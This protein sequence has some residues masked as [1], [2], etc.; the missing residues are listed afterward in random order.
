MSELSIRFELTN[1]QRKYFALEPVAPHWTRIELKPSTY[2]LYTTIAYLD[3]NVVRKCILISFDRYT[4]T[5]YN[6]PLSDDLQ[7]LL[8]KTA[9]GKPVRLTSANLLKRKS[10]GMCLHYEKSFVS[11]YSSDNERIYYASHYEQGPDNFENWVRQWCQDSTLD[12]IQNIHQFAQE[13]KNH[14]KYHEGD[15]FRFK[16]TRR[17]Y[18]YGRILLDYN[19]LRKDKVPFWDIWMSTPVVCSVYHIITE[20]PDI[21]VDELRGLRSL[22]STIIADNAFYYGTYEIIGNIPIQEVEDYPI[23]YGNSM[24]SSETAIC[25]QYGKLYKRIENKSLPSSAYMQNS[26]GWT[27]NVELDMLSQCIQEHA[28]DPYWKSYSPHFT[29]FDIRNPKNRHILKDAARRFHVQFPLV[30]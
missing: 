14:V 13:K 4:E 9:K 11:V 28:N 6:E 29:R 5:A 16:L 21:A 27:L 3:G 18:G 23:M 30:G 19:K 7:Y 10:H 17:L 20:T 25:L 15:V 24:D 12:D 2:D 8:P 22:P 1:E 26:I